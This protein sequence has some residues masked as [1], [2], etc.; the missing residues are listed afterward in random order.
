MR[1]HQLVLLT[2]Y[3]LCACSEP[4]KHEASGDRD[5]A[6]DLADQD[7]LEMALTSSNEPDINIPSLEV[8]NARSGGE[9][10]SGFLVGRCL[11]DR[12]VQL[13]QVSLDD[14]DFIDA[15][16]GV[17]WRFELPQES[18][19][20]R[21]G[22]VHR[23]SIRCIDTAKNVSTPNHFL[24][25]QGPKR[26]VNGDGF[27][28]LVFGTPNAPLPNWL[29]DGRR[30]D[31]TGRLY[32][33][34]GKHRGFAS[35]AVTSDR[36]DSIILGD[37]AFHH[38]ASQIAIGDINADGFADI[39]A[40]EPDFDGGRGRVSILLG[41]KSWP[42][43]GRLKEY[44]AQ[45]INGHSTT[46]SLGK[47]LVISDVNN[48][49]F[50]DLLVGQSSSPG[51]VFVLPGGGSGVANGL[52]SLGTANAVST[53]IGTTATFGSSLTSC[54]IDRDS[55]RDIVVGEPK[56]EGGGRIYI[57]AGAVKDLK[58]DSKYVIT[59][60][61]R[62]DIFGT[63]MV[64][65][66]FNGDL[67]NDLAISLLPNHASDSQTKGKIVIISGE[68]FGSQAEI[69]LNAAIARRHAVVL[70]GKSKSG[71]GLSLGLADFERDGI[72]DLIVG[73]PYHDQNRGRAYVFNGNADFFRIQKTT[74]QRTTAFFSGLEVGESLGTAVSGGGDYN[75]DGQAD[76]VLASPAYSLNAQQ[77]LGRIH[78]MYSPIGGFSADAL[79]PAIA[80]MTI[81]GDAAGLG[82]GQEIP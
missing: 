28:D 70:T 58:T 8:Y 46:G 67:I 57:Y 45:F 82:V 7:V 71:F 73:A 21:L 56:H 39:A 50:D 62:A 59:A 14:G 9:L 60:S 27:A 44:A 63:E 31:G 25:R 37:R 72:T 41:Q 68:L 48:D 3:F 51:R 18:R 19:S 2:G 55:I 76:L 32:L 29:E 74:R 11:D 66:D 40:S 79:A 17:E 65:A 4:A 16:G 69:D 47:S 5:D 61:N 36:A 30:Q 34:L 38:F 42:G 43:E 33:V 15:E 13:V 77:R 10:S 53:F 24:V 26:D 1:L 78:V 35:N 52:S 20:W 80:D 49:G 64:C 22:S 81:T 12:G 54:D 23:I 6:E 75:H